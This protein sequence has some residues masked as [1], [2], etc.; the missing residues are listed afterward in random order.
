MWPEPASEKR[1]SDCDL[2]GGSKHRLAEHSTEGIGKDRKS[3][4]SQGDRR[5]LI[6]LDTATTSR[7]TGV[8]CGWNERNRTSSVYCSGRSSRSNGSACSSAIGAFV[9]KK[10]LQSKWMLRY[11]RPPR[12][13]EHEQWSNRPGLVDKQLEQAMCSRRDVCRPNHCIAGGMPFRATGVRQW[14]CIAC[15]QLR[16]S[17]DAATRA[18]TMVHR[19][20]PKPRAS[21]RYSP[22]AGMST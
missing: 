21:C 8:G 19:G 10:E 11:A 4:S 20:T 22:A 15:L 12:C 1:E 14:R 2:H 3:M 16:S 7:G 9:G 18:G 6:Q 5:V 17:V 13:A